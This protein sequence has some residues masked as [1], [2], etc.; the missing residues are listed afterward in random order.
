[1]LEKFK[2]K[3]NPSDEEILSH[4]KGV[5]GNTPD[6]APLE[7]Q[8]DEED[9]DSSDE[10]DLAVAPTATNAENVRKTVQKES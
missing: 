2:E 6:Q 9:A 8:A 1:M 7:S 3:E 4:L 5:A 10:E